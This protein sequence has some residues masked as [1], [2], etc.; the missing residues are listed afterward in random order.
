VT[1]VEGR[2]ALTLAALA[3]VAV[4][5]LDPVGVGGHAVD[6]LDYDLA[7]VSDTR[8]RRWVVRA[9]RRKTAAAALDVESRLLPLLAGRLPFAVPEPAGYGP[10]PEGGRCMVY[11][12][13]P[14]A[15]L[16]PGEL[17]P[18]AGMAPALGK[19]LAAVHDLP[20]EVFDEAGVPTYT[21]EQYRQRLL[22]D[23]DRAASTGHV[24]TSLLT[25]WEAAL[26]EVS[27]WR[28]PTTPVHGDLAAEHVLMADGA[29]TGMIDWGEARVA[30]PADDL[31]W[32]AVGADSDALDSVLESYAMARSDQPDRH[33]LDR[34]QLAGELSFARWLL[35]GVAADDSA[36]IDQATEALRELAERSAPAGE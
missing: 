32:V 19:A 15:A 10:L 6:G 27:H 25:R 7:V 3:S 4:P 1:V 35:T 12:E 24:P 26:E 17:V 34:A 8:K 28:F 22:S 30:D 21:A 13:L 18:G 5:G 9:P 23:V 31:A 36:I 2:S 29:V 20:H 16:H 14:G 11:P 33:L